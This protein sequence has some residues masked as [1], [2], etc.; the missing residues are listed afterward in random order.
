[1]LWL[2]P[3][4][5]LI[6]ISS[7]SYVLRNRSRR[8]RHDVLKAVRAQLGL[9]SIVLVWCRSLAPRYCCRLLCA[10]RFS[11]GTETLARTTAAAEFVP[12]AG[13]KR[14][15]CIAL[16]PTLVTVLFAGHPLFGQWLHYRTPGLPRNSNGEPILNAPAP[17]QSN[18]TPDLSGLWGS[19]QSVKR[20]TNSGAAFMNLENALVPGS[21]IS[22]LSSAPT[23]LRMCAT[24]KKTMHTPSNNRSR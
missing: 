5:I 16:L 20:T 13:M 11:T 6:G 2:L 19:V 24:T 4:R 1:M 7:A 10:C 12:T 9:G 8:K 14:H 17:H 18:G 23:S 3:N 22:M 21:T 15:A